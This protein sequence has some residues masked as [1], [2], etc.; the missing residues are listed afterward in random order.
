MVAGK[1]LPL[2]PRFLSCFKML[3]PRGRSEPVP[4][5]ESIDKLKEADSIVVTKALAQRAGFFSAMGN[6]RR[7]TIVVD[8]DPIGLL[9]WSIGSKMNVLRG[10]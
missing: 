3:H 4:V 1:G 5:L 10:A 2:P 9:P 8:E 7:N 6:P